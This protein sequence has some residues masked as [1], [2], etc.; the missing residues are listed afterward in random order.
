MWNTNCPI[1]L[2]VITRH[3]CKIYVYIGPKEL[4]LCNHLTAPENGA[5]PTF[6]WFNGLPAEAHRLSKADLLLNKCEANSQPLRMNGRINLTVKP[7]NAYPNLQII[8]CLSLVVKRGAGFYDW[9][10]DEIHPNVE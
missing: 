7:K 3:N 6:L 2:L 10:D 4:D 8:I 9:H 5:G 1:I